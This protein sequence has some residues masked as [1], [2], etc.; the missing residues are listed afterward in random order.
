M[1]AVLP[2]P[3]SSLATLGGEQDGYRLAVREGPA[4]PLLCAELLQLVNGARWWEKD[5]DW[6]QV[7]FMQCLV[8]CSKGFPALVNI[9]VSALCALQFLSLH[10]NTTNALI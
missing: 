3:S 4:E 10:S 1:E 6:L 2:E 5:G 8:Q 9:A 7:C